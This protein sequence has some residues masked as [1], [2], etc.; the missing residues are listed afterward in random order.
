[1]KLEL[2][3]VLSCTDIGCL[4]RVLRDD[5][6]IETRYSELVKDRIKISPG[7]L[8]AIDK[9]V[10][11]SETVWR[12]VHAKVKKF[13]GDRAIVSD[14][15]KES[16]SVAFVQELNLDIQPGDDVWVCGVGYDYEVHDKIVEGKP[17]HPEKLLAY[18]EPTITSIYE[19][20][21]NN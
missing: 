4:V 20:A 3:I 18:I 13:E 9:G 14:D 7:Q 6:R 15:K 12:W 2:A 17:A 5:K 10:D 21:V 16:V 1:M 8:V 11:P 19:E